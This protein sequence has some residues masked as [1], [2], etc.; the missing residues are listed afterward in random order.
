MHS[1]LILRQ[2]SA[3]SRLKPYFVFVSP[4]PQLDKLNRLIAAISGDASSG[5]SH[6]HHHHQ[7]SA[8]D[9]QSIIDEARDI[10][11]RYGHYFDMILTVT[12]IQRAYDELL[13]E[14]NALERNAQWIPIS[15]LK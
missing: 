8:Y 11:S 10:E 5:Q 7:M 15:W 2:G 14:I 6:H 13:A 1:I 4:P 12:D 9:L 3:G